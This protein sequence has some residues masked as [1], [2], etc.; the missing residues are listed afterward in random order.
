MRRREV[1]TVYVKTLVFLMG[2]DLS[3]NPWLDH[4]SSQNPPPPPPYSS[5]LLVHSPTW[6]RTKR[7][8]VGY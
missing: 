3:T 6:C 8:D 5:D 2:F 7:V 1:L 4:S